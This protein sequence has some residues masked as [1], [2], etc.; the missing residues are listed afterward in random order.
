MTMQTKSSTSELKCTFNYECPAVE[1]FASMWSAENKNSQSSPLSPHNLPKKKRL[2]VFLVSVFKITKVNKA[3][4]SLD[5]EN[6]K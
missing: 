3:F 6:V 5:L 4:E 2:C 1:F